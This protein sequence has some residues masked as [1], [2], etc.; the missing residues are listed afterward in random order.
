MQ[1]ASRESTPSRIEALDAPLLTAEVGSELEAEVLQSQIHVT[2]QESEAFAWK[3]DQFL[4]EVHA[5]RSMGGHASRVA[6]LQGESR[7]LR[8]KLLAAQQDLNDTSEAEATV[9][10]RME[11]SSER[12]TLEVH[13]MRHQSMLSAE[14]VANLKDED[15]TMREELQRS[16]SQEVPGRKHED[17]I[18]RAEHRRRRPEAAKTDAMRSYLQECEAASRAEAK[19][20]QVNKTA[21]SLQRALDVH[22]EKEA[23]AQRYIAEDTEQ[24]LRVATEKHGQLKSKLLLWQRLCQRS[25]DAV[26]K[27][28]AEVEHATSRKQKAESAL[29]QFI[30]QLAARRKHLVSVSTEKELAKEELVSAQ[31]RCRTFVGSLWALVLVMAVP[32]AAFVANAQRP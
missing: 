29:V 27:L 30:S 32:L 10:Q 21:A 20:E 14:V 9:A 16:R 13:E 5:L 2:E 17:H 31:Q 19:L 12:L 26:D 8:D 18:M 28:E 6:A 24:K 25:K 4:A 11:S 1:L 22:R 3:R 23:A 15:R 7:D